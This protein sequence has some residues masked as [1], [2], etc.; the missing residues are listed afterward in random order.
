[1]VAKSDP[2]KEYFDRLWEIPEEE[3]DYQ[4]N[5]KT[6]AKDWEDAEELIPVDPEEL[7]KLTVPPERHTLKRTG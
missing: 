7:A 3:I 2:P 4:A 6:T 1:M 5:P